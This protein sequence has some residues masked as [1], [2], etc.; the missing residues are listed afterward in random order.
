MS[1]SDKLRELK[2]NGAKATVPYIC[3]GDPNLDFSE[4]LALRLAAE[5]AALIELGLPYSDPVADG[6][7]IQRAAERALRNKVRLSDLLDLA[8]RLNKRIS[9]PLIIM[10]YYNP[11]YIMGE[12]SFAKACGASGVAG[13]II[14]DLPVEEAERLQGYLTKEGVELIFLLSPSAPEE[15]I[16]KIAAQSGGFIYCLGIDGVTGART[17][18]SRE[19]E[20]LVAK[21]RQKTSLPLLVGF[22]VSNR[23][24]AESLKCF[25][26]GVIVGSALIQTLEQAF[27]AGVSE[28]Q[29]LEEAVDFFREIKKEG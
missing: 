29:A 7:T 18:L 11:I 10:S 27:A 14:P 3:C 4:E 21:L 24:M 19:I 15:R 16:D 17:E 9:T 26:D 2:N 13:V 20:G 22:G 6:P 5:G 25:A 28:E 1:I 8:E 23:E 12:E